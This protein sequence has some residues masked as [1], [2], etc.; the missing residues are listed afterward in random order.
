MSKTYTVRRI[1]ILHDQI[2][3]YKFD[4]VNLALT[5][6]NLVHLYGD[7]FGW[8]ELVEDILEDTV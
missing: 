3:Y 4:T 1:D 2:T 7:R 5:F 6:I 8:Y